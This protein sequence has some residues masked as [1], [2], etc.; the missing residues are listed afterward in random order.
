MTKNRDKTMNRDIIFFF[1]I[2]KVLPY[3]PPLAKGDQ[4]H[5]PLSMI[6]PS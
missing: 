6:V 4:T 2:V 5:A 3:R 1:F